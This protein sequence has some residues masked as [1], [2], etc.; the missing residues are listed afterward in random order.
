[1]TTPQRPHRALLVLTAA[2]ADG[3]GN[4]PLSVFTAEGWTVDV[5]RVGDRSR[6]TDRDRS[7]HD[8]S[9]RDRSDRDCADYDIVCFVDGNTTTWASPRNP[10]VS[11]LMSEISE[12][13]EVIAA[14]RPAAFSLLEEF[15]RRDRR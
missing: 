1:M 13:G 5:T 2:P 4:D 6:G 9:D 8:R 11:R 10:D 15:S 7:D 3:G 12:Y 14:V